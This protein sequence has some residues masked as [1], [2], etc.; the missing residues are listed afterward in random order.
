M[1]FTAGA[2]LAKEGPQRLVWPEGTDVRCSAGANRHTG[3]I[4]ESL[5]RSPGCSCFQSF[6]RRSRFFGQDDSGIIRADEGHG[7]IKVE[8][9]RDIHGNSDFADG[10]IKARDGDSMESIPK[11]EASGIFITVLLPKLTGLPTRP[12]LTRMVRVR[13]SWSDVTVM[14]N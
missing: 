5:A 7:Q 3:L 13:T 4:I 10:R 6:G 14:V 12:V 9:V 2:A 11:T 1:P 8:G